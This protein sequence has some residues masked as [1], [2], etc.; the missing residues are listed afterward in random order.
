VSQRYD[1]PPLDVTGQHITEAPYWQGEG[2]TVDVIGGEKT[3]E[4]TYE[5]VPTP[6]DDPDPET[7]GQTTLEDW[8]WSV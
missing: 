1:G 3:G 6:E 8:G 2:E 4:E 7:V 5:N